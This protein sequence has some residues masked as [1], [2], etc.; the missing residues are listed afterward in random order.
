MTRKRQLY[1]KPDDARYEYRVWGEHRKA[2]KLMTKLASNETRDRV[3]DCYLLVDDPSWNAKVRDNTLKVKQL[4]A[5]N[6]GFEQWV[7]GRHRSSDSAP[8]PFDALFD[9]L[10]LDRPQ[11]GKSYDLSQAVQQLNP[12]LGVKAV[13]VTKERRRFRIGKLRAEVTDI[14][15]DETGELLRTLSIEGDNLD[16]LVSLRKKLGLR[17]QPNIA[18]HQAIDNEAD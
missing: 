4:V 6:E 1:D 18:V 17:E 7:S 5:E 16:E 15:I 8:S 12:D 9:E 14:E 11:K 2:R 13:F 3:E 10:R